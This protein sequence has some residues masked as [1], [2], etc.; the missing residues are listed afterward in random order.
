MTGRVVA[1]L[2]TAKPDEI[3]VLFDPSIFHIRT[4]RVYP[5]LPALLRLRKALVSTGLALPHIK[6]RL[7]L[8]FLPWIS[9]RW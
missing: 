5:T 1:R 2:A 9:A 7:K 4:R 8:G 6:I 3:L